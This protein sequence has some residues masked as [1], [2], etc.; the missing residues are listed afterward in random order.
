MRA[1]EMMK[2]AILDGK[3][4]D[5]ETIDP[6]VHVFVGTFRPPHY[7]LAKTRCELYCYTNRT[8]NANLECWKSGH[9]D[10]PQ[11]AT[12]TPPSPAALEK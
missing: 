12:I 7:T 8:V 2:L 1:E 10:L 4:V 5:A 3:H 9:L 6:S 11:Y